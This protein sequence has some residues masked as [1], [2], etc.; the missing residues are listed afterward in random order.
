MFPKGVVEDRG[1]GSVFL[2]GSLDAA[3]FAIDGDSVLLA[4]EPSEVASEGFKGSDS[5]P[6]NR[7]G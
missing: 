1:I 3:R 7:A 6:A 4:S 2:E 5:T